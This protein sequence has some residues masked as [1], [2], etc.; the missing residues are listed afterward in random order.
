MTGTERT[1]IA[2]VVAPIAWAGGTGNDQ[3][4]AAVAER[5][6]DADGY[7]ACCWATAAVGGS[8]GATL[9]KAVVV[10]LGAA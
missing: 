1:G 4:G 9:G 3:M 10:G 5:A 6:A 7:A 2:G 8:G